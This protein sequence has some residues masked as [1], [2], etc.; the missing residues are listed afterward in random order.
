MLK[1]QENNSDLAGNIL[2]EPSLPEIISRWQQ[3]QILL[4]ETEIQL[5][6]PADPDELLQ[7]VDQSEEGKQEE[8]DPYWGHLWPA[9]R[10]MSELVSL[11]NWNAGTRVLELGCGSGLIGIA[12]LAAGM[13]V[14][15]SDNQPDA[16][17]LAAY[18]ATQ[19]GFQNYR[20]S[21]Y[22]WFDPS[23]IEPFPIVIASDVLY[24]TRFHQPLLDVLQKVLTNQGEAWIADPGRSLLADFLQTAQKDHFQIEIYDEKLK[25]KSFPG[26][27]HFQVIRLQ[28]K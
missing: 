24:E 13:Q 19:N 23:A 1:N 27:G 10:K 3:K 16:L 2:N 28:R 21:L 11:F 7:H 8:F 6:I 9:A 4:S 15:F 22:D 17:Q 20:L 14:T 12:A 26:I 18:N 5:T 25:Q